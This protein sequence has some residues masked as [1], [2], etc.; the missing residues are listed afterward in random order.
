VSLLKK[1]LLGLGITAVLISVLW[2]PLALGLMAG[3]PFA[4]WEDPVEPVDPVGARAT[5]EES[6]ACV[7]YYAEGHRLDKDSVA[8]C[9][10][11][12]TPAKENA[13]IACFNTYERN[14]PDHEG[15]PEKNMRGCTWDGLTA[16]PVR[17]VASL[18]FDKVVAVPTA[19]LAG[20]PFVLRVGLTRSDS[21]AKIKE[22]VVDETDNPAVNVAVTIGGENVAVETVEGCAPC[23]LSG[24]P[25]SEYW[26]SDGKI[27]VRFTV[28][29]T[30]AGKRVA[31]KMTV[32]EHD[33]PTVTKDVTFTVRR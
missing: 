20:K 4:L 30:A 13:L 25:E 19:P 33:T 15:W 17:N 24:N 7:G 12:Q 14:H 32:A 2:F 27:W 26:F 3:F 21:A 11:T 29:E 28:P 5:F 31:I 6:A 10:P 1:G 22:R 9:F 16:V 8:F 18:A 23:R